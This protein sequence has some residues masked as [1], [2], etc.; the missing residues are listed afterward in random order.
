M[1]RHEPSYWSRESAR[2][3]VYPWQRL[4]TKRCGAVNEKHSKRTCVYCGEGIGT[5]RDHIPPKGLFAKP[6][7]RLVTVPCCTQCQAGQS[8]DDEYFLR[9]VSMRTGTAD[10]ASARAARDSAL[11]S[12]TKLAKTRF[13]E[14][15]LRAVRESAV[16][17]PAGI[18][19]GQGLIYDVDLH[20]LCRVIERTT[21]G[22]YFH[23]F[24]EALPS[25]HRC[26][27]YC[28]DGFDFAGPEVATEVQRFWRHAVSGERRDFG[29]AVFTYWVQRIAGPEDATLWGF[30]VYGSV[31]FLA[32]TVPKV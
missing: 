31:A 16:Y 21:R 17:S 8:L 27:V 32:F 9:M 18:Y 15:L 30:L 29:E 14:S 10:N 1:L 7:P 3:E 26:K 4:A 24:G 5:T 2:R 19:L 12:L 28:I 20:R 22:L 23:E 25:N 11:R 13:A 6:R